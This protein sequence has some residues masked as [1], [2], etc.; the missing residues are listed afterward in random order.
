MADQIEAVSRE[1]APPLLECSDGLGL[2]QGGGFS[3]RLVLAVSSLPCQSS[4]GF[5]NMIDHEDIDWSLGGLTRF[6]QAV[7]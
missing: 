5:Y 6:T 7:S 3:R 1:T 4:E 2:Y